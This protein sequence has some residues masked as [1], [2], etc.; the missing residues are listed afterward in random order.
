MKKYI[1]LFVVMLM[2]ILYSP[3]V[4]AVATKGCEDMFGSAQLDAKI[5]D[6]VHTIIVIIQIAVPVVLVI[7]GMIDLFK[8]VTAGKEDEMKKAQG[9]FVKRLISAAL[10]FFVV[11]IVRLV[12]GIVADE[13]TD[14]WSCADC[15]LNGVDTSSGACK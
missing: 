9:I 13:D 7:I 5:P 8:G 14:I 3:S 4:F 12:I 10:V 2:G 1:K 15:F 11:A 6:L